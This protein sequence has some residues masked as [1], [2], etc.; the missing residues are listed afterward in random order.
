MSDYTRYR[1]QPSGACSPP[2]H[3]T[4]IST[5][6]NVFG[7]RLRPVLPCSRGAQMRA[8]GA[9]SS[10]SAAPAFLSGIV[11]AVAAGLLGW[12]VLRGPGIRI[13]TSRPAV[14]HR[15]QQLQRLETVVY[16][17]DKIVS[18]GLENKYLPKVLVGERI[19]LTVYGE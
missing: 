18:G 17:M 8:R 13:D 5:V 12:W 7:G 3:A 9:A 2:P 14:V 10:G 4:A 15:I 19:L 16:G 6:V 1:W 11:L